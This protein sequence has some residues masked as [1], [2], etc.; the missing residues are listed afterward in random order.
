MQPGFFDHDER[1]KKLEQ[2]GDPLPQIAR[3]V[4]WEGFRSTLLQ[5]WPKRSPEGG[6]PPYDAVLMFK[7]LVLQHLYN[8]SD[9]QVEFQI[10]DRYS[11][12]RFVGLAPEQAVPDAKTVWLYRERLRQGQ[13]TA[14]VFEQLLGQIDAAGFM[15]RKGQI[16]D[17]AIVEVPRQRNRREENEQIKAGEVPEEWSAAKRRQKDIQ[18]RWTK[19]YG[20]VHFGYKNHLSADVGQ[21]LIRRYEVTAATVHDSQVFDGLLDEYNS[22]CGVWADAAYRSAERL[23][24]LRA[25][26]YQAHLQQQGQSKAPLTPQQRASNRRRARVRCLIEHVFAHQSNFGQRLV[27]T[28]GLDRATVKIGL[29]NLAY[30]LRRWAFLIR[31]RG[32]PQPAP[33]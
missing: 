23:Q 26:G 1:L 32:S 13:L 2:L 3:L 27:R 15:A 22:G 33:A 29:F 25:Q 17:A 18:A 9:E 14:V 19:K 6:R 5:A 10:R 12:A 24:Q 4:D 30:N 7:V 21:R 28:I 11:F 8:L 20:A 31:S 16:V